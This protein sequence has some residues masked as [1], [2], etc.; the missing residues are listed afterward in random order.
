MGFFKGWKF[1]YYLLLRH[2]FFEVLGLFNNILV[3]VYIYRLKKKK[4]N[5]VIHNDGKNRLLTKKKNKVS[6]LC[7]NF[8]PA[9]A[10]ITT[11]ITTNTTN[12]RNVSGIYQQWH[13]LKYIP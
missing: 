7:H 9:L 8:T 2:I 3:S 13:F 11:Y 1:G 10:N 4:E 6:E 12:I 5:T